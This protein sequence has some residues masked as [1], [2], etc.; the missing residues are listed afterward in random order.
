MILAL[1]GGVGGARLAHGLAQCLAPDELTIVVNTGDDFEHLGLAISPDPDT[2]LYTLSGLADP[3]RGWGQKDETWSMMAQLEALGGET[4]F[5][6]GDRDLAVNL[7]RTRR[8]AAGEPLSAITAD[9]AHRLGI[10]HAIAPMS[11]DRVRS[12]V[13][14]DQGTLPFQDYFVRLQCAPR[15]QAIE[16][17]GAETASPSEALT[18]ALDDPDLE[19]VIL[20][21]SNPWLSIGPL[22]ALPGV[23]ARLAG[24]AAPVIAVSP[25]IGG[26][27]VKG[28]AAKMFAELGIEPSAMAV[29]QHY[30][31]LIDGLVIDHV[32]RD[33][34]GPEPPVALYATN[35]LMRDVADRARL[36]REVIAFAKSIGRSRR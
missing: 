1:A 8:L 28:P 23:R 5:A 18:A 7:E 16:Y 35:A 27:A 11:N 33:S 4:W 34:F 29:A 21:P 32:D 17:R 3:V 9:F 6:L 20:C 19:A 26:K 12:H 36:G 24:C 10:A 30:E 22:L 13:V 14:T 25:I 2:V 15:V 31:G